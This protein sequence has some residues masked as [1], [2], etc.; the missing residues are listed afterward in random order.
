MSSP[1]GLMWSQLIHSGSTSRNRALLPGARS[2]ARMLTTLGTSLAK[3]CSDTH[4]CAVTHTGVPE[5]ST[6]EKWYYYRPEC[7]WP[8]L[9]PGCELPKTNQTN[10]TWLTLPPKPLNFEIYKGKLLGRVQ[11]NNYYF[12][13]IFHEGVPPPPRPHPVENNSYLYNNFSNFCFVF[14]SP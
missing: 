5:P 3:V 1:T 2:P 14:Q 13:G 10:R 8:K 7:E 6:G 11:K 9:N 12:H 4:R